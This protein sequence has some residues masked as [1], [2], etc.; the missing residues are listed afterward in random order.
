MLYVKDHN[1]GKE[2]DNDYITY[3]YRWE[4]LKQKSEF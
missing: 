1:D 2:D 3:T 4:L